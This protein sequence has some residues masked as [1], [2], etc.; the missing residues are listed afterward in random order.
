ML[1]HPNN[2]R[3]STISAMAL[4]GTVNTDE[5]WLR[6][7]YARASRNTLSRR[8]LQMS[9]TCL[10]GRPGAWSVGVPRSIETPVNITFHVDG[11]RYPAT[12]GCWNGNRPSQDWGS[13]DKYE[14]S[15]CYGCLAREEAV[16]HAKCPARPFAATVSHDLSR[17]IFVPGDY[18]QGVAVIYFYAGTSSTRQPVASEDAFHA[19]YAQH[20]DDLLAVSASVIGV[21]TEPSGLQRQRKIDAD[22]PHELLSEPG[23]RIAEELGLPNGRSGWGARL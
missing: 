9:A 6:R 14:E 1:G 18:R 7:I 23:L 17:S 5:S 10:S 11:N 12:T 22:I 21:S 15:C 4:R 13:Y 16:T 2:A 19:S 3:S 8:I 20:R